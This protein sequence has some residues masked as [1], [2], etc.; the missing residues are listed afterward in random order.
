MENALRQS[1]FQDSVT[2]KVGTA[3]EIGEALQQLG[4]TQATVSRALSSFVFN[5]IPG[6]LVTRS[7]TG[8][9][10]GGSDFPE[11]T[12]GVVKEIGTVHT[13]VANI[14]RAAANDER[15]L[16]AA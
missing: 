6:G 7:A 3:G 8:F 1:D 4:A 11:T 12:S 10:I 9:L 14:M 16:A 2:L 13:V 15:F 5:K